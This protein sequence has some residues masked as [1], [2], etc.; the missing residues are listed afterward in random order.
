MPT[1]NRHPFF[2]NAIALFALV[3]I[4]W[5]VEV[6]DHL[7]PSAGIDQRGVIPRDMGGLPGILFSPFLHGDFQHLIGNTIPFLALGGL[8]MLSGLDTF[9][10]VCGVV[11][12]VGGAG[13]W[14]FAAAGSNHIGA[15]TLVFGFLGYLLLRAWFSRDWRWAVVALVAGFFYGGLVATLFKH[16]PGV[17]WHGHAFGFAG[18]AL[19]AWLLT[20]RAERSAAR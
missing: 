13:I 6:V 5:G 20:P 3:A 9:F 10:K 17:S 15:S 14:L 12:F 19:A 16:I 4:F 18:G 7:I 11:M 1:P 8:V 2:T